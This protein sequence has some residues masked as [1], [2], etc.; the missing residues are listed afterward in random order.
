M[1]D[2]PVKLEVLPPRGQNPLVRLLNEGVAS[3]G[4]L[5]AITN[6]AEHI[7]GEDVSVKKDTVVALDGHAILVT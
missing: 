3:A 4:A 2:L 5:E 7:T 1:A 6:A